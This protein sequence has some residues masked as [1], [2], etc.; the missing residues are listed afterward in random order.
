MISLTDAVKERLH[1]LRD[2]LRAEKLDAVVVTKEVNLHYFSGF[3][4]D[5]TALVVTRK[6]ALLITDNRYT[7][8]AGQ[9]A[10]LYKVVEQRHGLF[11]KTAKCLARIGVKRVGFE[12]AALSYNEYR[13]LK[14]LLSDRDI[15]LKKSLDL[16]ILREVKD[17][18]ELAKLRKACE[19]ADA[20]FDDI[21]KFIRPGVTELAVA[22]H[23]ENTMRELGSEEPSFTTIVASGIR[24]SMPHATATTAEIQTGDFVTMDYG[25]VYDGY[26]SDITRTVCVGAASDRQKE[27]Y[28][29]VLETQQ[30]VLP[31]IKTGASGRDVHMAAVA[32]LKKYDLA[33]YFGHGLGHS[34]GLEIHEEPRLSPSST[35]ESLLPGMVITD[36]PGVYLPGYGGLRIE[37]SVLVTDEGGEPLT[38]S[39]KELIEI[40]F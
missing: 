13:Q 39:A 24:G 27:L 15:K 12:G 21:V 30:S 1:M 7:E 18:L 35:C 3:R 40:R 6:K 11:K 28:H 17:E 26:H 8:Q 16:D 37:D 31:L 2:V 10:P 19:I 38:K 32:N 23:L 14:K 4:G 22:A 5:D 9:Q 20:A 29:A 34:V 36:E 33:Q 25:A